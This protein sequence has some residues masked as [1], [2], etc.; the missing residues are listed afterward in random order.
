MTRVR[1]G[2]DFKQ[3]RAQMFW[4]RKEAKPTKTSD[5][6]SKELPGGFHKKQI[7]KQPFPARRA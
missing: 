3:K 6:R 4:P 7:R 2:S 1:S 5:D